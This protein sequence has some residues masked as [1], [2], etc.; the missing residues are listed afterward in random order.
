MARDPDFYTA[1]A[2]RL[3]L[4]THYTCG[5]SVNSWKEG[6]YHVFECGAGGCGAAW[7]VPE[8]EVARYLKMETSRQKGKTSGSTS[9]FIGT[10][11]EVPG[12][13]TLG[14][15]ADRLDSAGLDWALTSLGKEPVTSV[16]APKE[17]ENLDLPEEIQPALDWLS[18]HLG[19]GIGDWARTVFKAIVNGYTPEG[20]EEEADKFIAS[21]QEEP[22]IVLGVD[23]VW[24]KE[25]PFHPVLDGLVYG[26][27]ET[28]RQRLDRKVA[29][30]GADWESVLRLVG[31]YEEPK[32]TGKNLDGTTQS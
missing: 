1:E 28:I 25:E 32:P 14:E 29:E 21:A 5:G 30:H 2:H 15:L 26:N 27:G 3:A 22:K 13:M 11:W 31:E 12:T 9:V 20:A 7:Q 17:D 4:E 8:A 24:P 6:R 18:D 16:L 23:P 10:Q 19:V